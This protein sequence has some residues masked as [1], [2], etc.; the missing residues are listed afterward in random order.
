[1]VASDGTDSDR[2]TVTI[3][4]IANNPPVFSGGPRSFSVRE[5]TPSGRPIGSPV[6]ATDPDAGDTVTHALEGTDAASFAIVASS[7]QIQTRATLD[8]STK[9]T[10]SVTVRATDNR[11]GSATIAVTINVTARPRTLGCGTRGA[12]DTSDAS[13][14]GLVADCE[15]LLKAT[16]SL[17]NGARIL[18]WSVT[19][20]ISEWDGIRGRSDALTGTPLRVTKLWLHR[21]GLS[22]T[23]PPEL[24]DVSELKWLYLHGNDL[25]GEIPGALNRLSKLERLYVYDNDLTG[26]SSQLGSGMSQLRRLFAQRNRISG[27]IPAGLGDMPRLD[28]LRLDRN[29]LTGSLPSRLGNLRTLRRLYLHEQEGWRAPRGGLTG[30]IPSTFGNMTRLEYLVLNR[31][32]LSGPI[33][34]EVALLSNLKWLGLYDNSFTGSIPSELGGLSS[35]E[36]LYLH[37][38]DLSG[39]IPASLSSLGSLTTCGSRTTSWRARY[40]PSWAAWTSTGCESAATRA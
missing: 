3:N 29:R 40:R 19:R 23:I 1:M 2:I 38:N 18:N 8:A 9:A 31:N 4:V 5:D 6:R 27:S 24:G 36:R 22:G 7:G 12:V 16:D 15:A 35:L 30:G 26:I 39:Q 21:M 17:E 14:T 34:P 20:P 11:G 37:G 32:S 33:P 25:T 28:F 13:N 10:Y